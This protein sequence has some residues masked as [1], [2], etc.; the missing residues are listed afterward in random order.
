MYK[1]CINCGIFDIEF[2]NFCPVCGSFLLTVDEY[3]R[4]MNNE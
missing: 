2:L 3:N 1:V 4:M